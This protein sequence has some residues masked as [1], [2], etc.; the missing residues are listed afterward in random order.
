ML[1]KEADFKHALRLVCIQII[2]SVFCLATEQQRWQ[3][4]SAVAPKNDLKENKNGD[5]TVVLAHDNNNVEK[6]KRN[7]YVVRRGL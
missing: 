6:T 7:Y 4:D 5:Q 2:A 1:T 3:N